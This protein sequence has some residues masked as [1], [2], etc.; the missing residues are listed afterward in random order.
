MKNFIKKIIKYF[1]KII[2]FFFPQRFRRNSNNYFNL[3]LSLVYS[4][5]VSTKY[6]LK[7]CKFRYPISWILSPQYMKIGSGTSFGKFV[8]LT[9]WSKHGTEI[10]NPQLVIGL[11][12]HFGDFLHLT[13]SNKII[14][15]N[16][17]LTGRW[18]TITD[19][20][21]GDTDLS[22]LKIP[23]SERKIVSK[24]A[25]IIGDNV[26]IG[27]KA[28]ILPGV[29]IGDGAVIAANSVVTKDVPP[30]SIAAGNPAKIIKN[31]EDK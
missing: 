3:A 1:F 9:T 25:V 4:Q 22:S 20:S 14:I 10:F 13:C 12:C 31:L 5:W 11:N 21:H 29:S 30:Y 17:L 16:N 26:W 19:N 7:N 23:P 28:T 2:F 6:K 24:G 8:V 18:V 15:G 27:D